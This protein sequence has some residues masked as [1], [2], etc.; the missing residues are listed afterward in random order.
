[1]IRAPIVGRT[2]ERPNEELFYWLEGWQG[3]LVE[4]SRPGRPERRHVGYAA[5][6]RRYG[7][8]LAGVVNRKLAS[9]PV[10]KCH[11]ARNRLVA[12]ADRCW[13]IL[14]MEECRRRRD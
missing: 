9:L 12:Q 5:N 7:E 3:D 1:M 8:A 2:V 10:A 14:G 13:D 6:V 4:V 11:V